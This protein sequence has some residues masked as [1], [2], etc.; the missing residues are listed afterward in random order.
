LK[1][2]KEM[3][4]KKSNY[5]LLVLLLSAVILYGGACQTDEKNNNDDDSADDDLADDDSTDDDV[6]GDDDDIGDDDD[7]STY[8]SPC[9][10]RVGPVVTNFTLLVNDLP[11]TMPVIVQE[12]DALVISFDYSDADCDMNEPYPSA[13]DYH[14][15]TVRI[16]PDQEEPQYQELYDLLRHNYHPDESLL[17]NCSSEDFG[18]PYL[19]ELDPTDYL[20]P[21]GLTRTLPLRFRL[22]DSCHW[23]NDYEQDNTYLDFTV[24]AAK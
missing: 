6:S 15:P 5:L 4:M 24:E 23:P 9:D 7:S 16:D 20:L 19:L 13:P 10:D 1:R 2:F 22:W 3:K 21:E 11:V 8:P 12:A 17:H 18:A 14:F